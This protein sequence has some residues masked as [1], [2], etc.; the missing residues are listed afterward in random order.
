MHTTNLRKVGGSVML[1]V[2][3][4]LLDILDL[5]AGLKVDMEVENGKLVIVPTARPKYTLEEL[6]KQCDPTPTDQ[7]DDED[8]LWLDTKPVGRELI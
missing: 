4:V 7:I 8:R 6:I 5:R 1:A 2:P 3:P